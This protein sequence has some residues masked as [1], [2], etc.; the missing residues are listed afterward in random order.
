M[1]DDRLARAALSRLAEPGDRQV[2]QLL[3]QHGPTEAL[4]RVRQ[5]HGKLSRFAERVRR[6]DIERDLATAEKVGARLLIPGDAEWPERLGDLVIPPW[7]L[8]VRGPADL[9]RVTQRSVAVVGSRV[10]TAYGEQL[11]ADIAAGL[12]QRGWTVISGAAF[13]IDGAAHRGTLAV[14]GVTVAALAG[15]V[16]RPY[17][18][19]HGRLIGRIAETGA[20][21]SEVAPGSAPMRSRFLL[22]NRLIAAMARGTLVVEADLR[23]GSLNTLNTAVELGRPVGACPGPVTSMTSAGCHAKIRAGMATLVTS[24]SEVIDLVGDLGADACDEPRGV[25]RLTDE[26]GPDDARIH[27]GLPHRAWVDLAQVCN[28]SALAPM[29]ALPALARLV[30]LGL[31]ERREGTWRKASSRTCRQ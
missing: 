20:V 26:L 23:S 22:R 7:C 30:E 19:G 11:A 10:C 15:G 5:G 12:A 18:A 25:E 29:Q 14:E 16:D 24:A 1:T 9:A 31:A 6:L 8:W 17:P 4:D 3:V 21:L 2:H 13:G 28:A 27:D